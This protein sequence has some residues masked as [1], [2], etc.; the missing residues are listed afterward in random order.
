MDILNPRSLREDA[1]RALNRG[2]DPKKLVF[3]YAG[4]GLCISLLVT[5]L[6]LWLEQEISGAGGLSN[7]G[8][9]AIFS[10]AQQAM[11]ILAGIFSLC[12]ELGY[13]G[14]MLRIARGQYADHTDLK[15]GLQKFWPLMRLTLLQGLIYLALAILA[16]Q[17]GGLVFAMTPWA[18]PALEAILNLNAADP[19]S[20]TELDLINMITLMV[21]M[22]VICGIIYLVILIPFLYRLR[23]ARFCLLDDSDGRA[24]AAI[25]TS[26]KLMRRRFLSM[27]KVDLSLWFYYLANGVMI[28]LLSADLI[29][30]LLGIQP[31]MDAKVFSLV[32]YGIALAVQFAIQVMLRNKA[33]AVYITAYD[34][35]REKPKEDHAVVLGNI[36]DM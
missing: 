24:L 3:S 15:T 31:P 30:S 7:L 25:R 23:F 29:L 1:G 8:T 32:V 21:P 26:F 18:E 27:L 17:L 4:I 2:R 16:A 34:R 12:L 10:T 13:L 36:F 5:L 35:L 19:A 33:E 11:P 9:R 14:G 22:Y 6:D 28:L 20:L